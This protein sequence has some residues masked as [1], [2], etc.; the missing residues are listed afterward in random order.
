MLLTLPNC[1]Q[2][3]LVFRACQFPLYT[4]VQFFG[5]PMDTHLNPHLFEAVQKSAGPMF[6]GVKTLAF[7]ASLTIYSCLFFKQYFAAKTAHINLTT[8]EEAS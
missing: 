1:L 2:G 4:K 7:A 5:I 8:G 3:P 6:S